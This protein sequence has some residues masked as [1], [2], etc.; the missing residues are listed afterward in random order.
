MARLTIALAA[1]SLATLTATI[2]RADDSIGPGDR[3]RSRPITLGATMSTADRGLYGVKVD[4]AP[5]PWL[6]L[7]G[8][9][10]WNGGPALGAAL[11][12]R[13]IVGKLALGLG[14]GVTGTGESTE[15][16][17]ATPEQD[18]WFGPST[19]RSYD[20]QP[21]LWGSVEGT[22]EARTQH[23]VTMELAVGLAS[24]VLGG[25]Y[26]CTETTSDDGLL[27]SA[28]TAGVDCSASTTKLAP[29]AGI[30]IGYSPKL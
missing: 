29:Y 5:R 25:G 21:T 30:A 1:L 19:T 20:Y 17:D 27:G 8:V 24:P 16:V 10:G 15:T 22:L 9:G 13:Q 6:E 11:H 7:S 4:Y 28:T 14:V 3:W 12:V 26:A 23:G 2:A 18:Q